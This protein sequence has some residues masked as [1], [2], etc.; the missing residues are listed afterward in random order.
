MYYLSQSQA[1]NVLELFS[2]LTL[3]RLQNL[4]RTE[5]NLKLLHFF[6]TAVIKTHT[7]T[8]FKIDGF[9]ASLIGTDLHYEIEYDY[10]QNTALVSLLKHSGNAA[11]DYAKIKNELLLLVKTATKRVL[12]SK[13]DK[14][15]RRGSTPFGLSLCPGTCGKKSLAN[16]NDAIISGKL[17]KEFKEFCRKNNFQL[18]N[19]LKK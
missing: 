19:R 18:K 4:V 5:K 13:K 7:S 3:L 17:T 15:K 14:S 10:I 16:F 9:I 12:D 1:L 2:Q 11:V 8:S 6:S